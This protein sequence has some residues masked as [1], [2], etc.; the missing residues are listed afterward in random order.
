MVGDVYFSSRRR[1]RVL[2]DEI[3]FEYNIEPEE[4]STETNGDEDEDDFAD[5]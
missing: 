4:S 5:M 3:V 1:L 2:T